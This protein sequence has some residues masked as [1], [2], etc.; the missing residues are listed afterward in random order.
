MRFFIG[1]FF[2]FWVFAHTIA[3]DISTR[4]NAENTIST[5]TEPLTIRQG[6]TFYST[7]ISTYD[8]R[9]VIGSHNK[10][11][12][13]YDNKGNEVKTFKT[14]GWIHATPI[15]LSDSGIIIGCYDGY[16]YMFDKY[17]EYARRFRPQGFIF[18]EPAEIGDYIAFG[19]NRGKVVFYNPFTEAISYLKVKGLVHGSPM[20]TSDTILIIGSNS[21]ELNFINRQKEL[22]AAFKA[23][24]WIM[25]SKA[26]E[27]SSGLIIIGSYD[28]HLYAV[29]KA[30]ALIWKF[31]TEGKIHG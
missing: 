10:K 29:D 27:L 25:H 21:K 11:L 22:V 3:Q 6:G 13:F 23:K 26:Y 15:Q 30:G 18:S 9:A 12:H 8:N 5:L 31:K 20:I 2:S 14:S 16:F 1:L 19:N 7:P 17:G 28:K 4:Q 24:G